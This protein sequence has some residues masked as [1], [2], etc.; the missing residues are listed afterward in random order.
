MD[1]DG[2][3]LVPLVPALRAHSWVDFFGIIGI[4][5]TALAFAQLGEPATV[6]AWLR[7]GG[8]LAALLAFHCSVFLHLILRRKLVLPARSNDVAL[9]QRGNTFRFIYGFE[10]AVEARSHIGMLRVDGGDFRIKRRLFVS[11]PA[12]A[13]AVGRLA[14]WLATRSKEVRRYDAEQRP[15]QGLGLFLALTDVVRSSP[16]TVTFR[17]A[18]EQGRVIVPYAIAGSVGAVLCT[19]AVMARMVDSGVMLS[20][21][22]L[23]NAVSVLVLRR[24]QPEITV[25]AGVG[26]RVRRGRTEIRHAASLCCFKTRSGYIG[27]QDLVGSLPQIELDLP[28]RGALPCVVVKSRDLDGKDLSIIAH[29]M[30]RFLWGGPCAADATAR[31][32]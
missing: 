3:L 21:L 5:G 26:I 28:D 10:P 31:K 6:S 1:A 24:M 11:K 7:C 9:Q 12:A 2:T 29:A 16:D 13:M 15:S 17:V 20:I 8:Y 4:G 23:A 32:P 25:E 27:D 22:W 19:V 14:S 30:N 18:T